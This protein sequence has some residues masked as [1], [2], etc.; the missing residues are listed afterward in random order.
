M[1]WTVEKNQSLP[2]CSRISVSMGFAAMGTNFLQ[3]PDLSTPPPTFLGVGFKYKFFCM[4][5]KHPA[6]ELYPHPFSLF[7]FPLSL[8]G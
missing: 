4:L 5:G 3:A 8:L 1:L 7:P 2:T 6:T